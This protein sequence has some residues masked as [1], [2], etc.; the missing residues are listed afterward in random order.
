MNLENQ[1]SKANIFFEKGDY[2]SAIQ[3]YE[4]LLRKRPGNISVLN[5]LSA[6]YF[7]T[8]NIIDSRDLLCKV[9]EQFPQNGL[10]WNNLGKMYRETGQID[11]AL[12]CFQKATKCD[13]QSDTIASNLLFVL[14]YCYHLSPEKIAQAHVSWG[15][16][17]SRLCKHIYKIKRPGT[18]SQYRI[19]YVSPDFRSHSVSYFFRPLIKY[20]NKDQFDIYCYANVSVPDQVTLE[21][22]AMHV[23]WRDIYSLTDEEA[24]SMILD[25]DIDI[26]IDLAGHTHNNRLGLF[27]Q[28]LAP[29]QMT[30]L[31]YPNTTG[32]KTIDYRLTDCI[33]DPPSS[34]KYYSENL[35]Y[36]NPCFLCYAPLENSPQPKQLNTETPTFGSFNNIGKMNQYAIKVW[37]QILNQLPNSRLFLKSRVL[38]DKKMQKNVLK[39]FAKHGVREKQLEFC[40]YIRNSHTHFESYHLVDIALDTFPYNGTTTTFEALWMGVPVITL[41][42]KTHASR[43]GMSILSSLGLNDFIALTEAEYISK[44]IQLAQNKDLIHHLRDSLRQLISQSSLLNAKLFVK[45]LEDVYKKAYEQT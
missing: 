16:A 40:G 19:G 12:D 29:V 14:N 23:K 31:G 27:A 1:F 7:Q 8:G 33:A 20:H 25:D 26:L 3:L 15:K 43:V 9:V 35:L 36:L 5:N 38:D 39:Q 22:Q 41:A 18:K 32:L 4:E 6:A 37:S 24:M 30:Y 11:W 10:A 2:Q 21:L 17:K 45:Q 13:P 42:G 34:K 28:K 44:A